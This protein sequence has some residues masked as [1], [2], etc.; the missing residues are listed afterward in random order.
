[1][2]VL[3]GGSS[4]GKRVGQDHVL[5]KIA[6]KID[7]DFIYEEVKET[8]GANGNVSV[9]PPCILKMMLLLILY[10]GQ[11]LSERSFARSVRYGYKRA[12]WRRIWRVQILDFLVV[13]IQNIMVLVIYSV[14]I[15]SKNNRPIGRVE[16]LFYAL[17]KKARLG[18][19]S[20]L[21]PFN[22]MAGPLYTV[23]GNRP[24]TRSQ[25]TRPSPDSEYV[26][27][28]TMAVDAATFAFFSGHTP[29]QKE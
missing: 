24:P 21:V 23:L 22:S 11:H 19:I 29:L 28:H 7:F 6:E 10:I 5:Q 13:G 27:G 3:S 4:L 8:Y 15:L 25:S 12:R 2:Q 16:E 26:K 9:P 18:L 1:M 20:N 14:K 17:L